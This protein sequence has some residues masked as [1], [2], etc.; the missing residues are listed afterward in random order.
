VPPARKRLQVGSIFAEV[1]HSYQNAVALG[2]NPRKA[3]AED[4]GA[5]D[6]TVAGWIMEARN[7]E[8]GHLPPAERGKISAAPLGADQLD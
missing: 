6:A 8:R 1:A 3:V 2:L 7:P 5:A 4:T